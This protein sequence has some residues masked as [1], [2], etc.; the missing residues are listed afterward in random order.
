MYCVGGWNGQ[1]GMKQCDVYDPSLGRWTS[2]AP[3]NYGKHERH[4]C[5]PTPCR[6]DGFCSCVG[7]YQAAVTTRNGKLYAVG[8]CDAWNCL[9]SVEVYDPE[10]GVWDFLPAMNTARRGCGVTLYQ[11]EILSDNLTILPKH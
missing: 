9:S 11:S 4:G 6:P 10:T 7:R 3:L 8:G 5:Y 2:I 1:C